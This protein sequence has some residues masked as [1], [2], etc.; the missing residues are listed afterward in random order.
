MELLEKYLDKIMMWLESGAEIVIDKAPAFVQEVLTY[1]TIIYCVYTFLGCLLLVVGAI[2]TTICTR[3]LCN[4]PEVCDGWASG[5]IFSI[6]SVISG[7]VLVMM[8]TSS[9]IKILSAPTLFLIQ[10]I[11]ELL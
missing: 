9:L 5:V 8:Y 3:K 6:I 2:F 1:Y 4:D 11:S 10:K 7:L